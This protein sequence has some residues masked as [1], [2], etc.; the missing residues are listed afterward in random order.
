MENNNGQYTCNDYRGEMIL[1]ALKKKLVNKNL[2]DHE[3][4]ELKKE[5]EK[6]EKRIGL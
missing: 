5:I 3:R 4:E 2:S 6:V 1:I